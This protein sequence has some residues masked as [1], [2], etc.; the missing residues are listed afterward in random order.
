MAVFESIFNSFIAIVVQIATVGQW[1]A[2][3]V[4]AAFILALVANIT[5]ILLGGD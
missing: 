2:I 4:I 3:P 1:L 5:H